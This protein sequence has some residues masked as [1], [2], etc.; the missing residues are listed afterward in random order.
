MDEKKAAEF[1]DYLLD[2]STNA[3]DGVREEAI[4]LKTIE[5]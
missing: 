2:E 3:R 1:L 4:R 5:I